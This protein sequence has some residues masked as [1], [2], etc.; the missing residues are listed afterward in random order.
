MCLIQG[1][2]LWVSWC[3]LLTYITIDS[4]EFDTYAFQSIT[5]YQQQFYFI[6]LNRDRDIIK[7]L[8]IYSMHITEASFGNWV[9]YI[10][11][12]GIMDTYKSCV[13][14]VCIGKLL[15]DIHTRLYVE[16]KL[17]NI[18]NRLYKICAITSICS[19]IFSIMYLI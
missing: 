12:C 8:C 4:V 18:F 10:H 17:S 9:I 14:Q 15:V 19:W 5:I 16:L 6:L 1:Q 7:Y 13:L 2:W 11:P 3:T